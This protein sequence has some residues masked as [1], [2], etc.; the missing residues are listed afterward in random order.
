MSDDE[1]RRALARAWLEGYERAEDFTED[2]EK[3]PSA[4]DNPYIK[5]G[6][7]P[8]GTPKS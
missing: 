7:S 3:P 6:E 4:W 2:D 5:P 8:D 1:T